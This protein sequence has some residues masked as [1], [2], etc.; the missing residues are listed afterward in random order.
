MFLF[1]QVA[2]W[3]SPVKVEKDA[4][5]NCVIHAIIFPTGT[6][7]YSS[8]KC[9]WCLR[10]AKGKSNVTTGTIHLCL[11]IKQ[12]KQI[13]NRISWLGTSLWQENKQQI[14]K[15]IQ[16][17]YEASLGILVVAVSRKDTPLPKRN[18]INLVCCTCSG[19]FLWNASYNIL[20]VHRCIQQ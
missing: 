20:C 9:F 6:W 14:N 2:W 5:L 16:I 12:R 17:C 15:Q 11:M 7:V 19:C 4:S 13:S 1:C 10:C 3:T 8:C 18:D